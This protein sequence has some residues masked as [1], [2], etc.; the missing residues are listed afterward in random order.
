LINLLQHGNAPDILLVTDLLIY[1]GSLGQ[2]TTDKSFSKRAEEFRRLAC[3][4]TQTY[5]AL[6][7]TL[8]NKDIQSDLNELIDMCNENEGCTTA[9]G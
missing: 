3:A 6:I 7:H 9:S 8:D 2:D 4:G 1:A 5:T